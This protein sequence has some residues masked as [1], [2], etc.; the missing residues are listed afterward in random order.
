MIYDILILKSTRIVEITTTT[1]R[2]TTTTTANPSGKFQCDFDKD[3]CGWTVTENVE[4]YKWQR[5]SAKECNAGDF[6]S[7][8]PSDLASS[9]EGLH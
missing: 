6:G 2:T 8:P 1:T 3:M 9:E 7:C 5:L 4:F